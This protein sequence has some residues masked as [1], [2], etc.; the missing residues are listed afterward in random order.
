M[1]NISFCNAEGPKVSVIMAVR[2]CASYLAESIDSILN[3]TFRDFEF[4][5]VDDA[6][7]DATPQILAD[8]A[9]RDS[10]IRLLCNEQNLKLAASLNVALGIARAPLI[11]RMDGDDWAYPSRLE[12][13]YAYMKAHPQIDICGT[14]IECFGDQTG[15]ISW[16]EHHDVIATLLLFFNAMAHPTVM[17]RKEA[18]SFGYNPIYHKAQDYELWSRLLFEHGCRF[19]NLP[20]V[21]L[22]YRSDAKP[23]FEP[24]HCKISLRN[25]QRL[26]ITATEKQIVIHEKLSVGGVAAVKGKYAAREIIDWLFL[27]YQ[28]NLTCLTVNR[29]QLF[30]LFAPWILKML[31]TLTLT[32]YSVFYMKRI[33]WCLRESCVL[34][35]KF[36]RR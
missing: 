17:G 29:T 13:Q 30:K 6:S 32:E 4:I 19:G 15:I 28:A 36:V 9:A 35:S 12:L 27:I 8:Y 21:L 24:F 25:V 3:Q 20:D 31:P 2:N 23:G 5:I 1:P 34:A 10:R 16:P 18:F 11:A 26:G 22:R 7:T 33:L 14:A